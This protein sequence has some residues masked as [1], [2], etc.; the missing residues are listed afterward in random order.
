MSKDLMKMLALKQDQN[1]R[2]Q[3]NQFSQSQR[4][5]FCPRLEARSQAFSPK[6]P[7]QHQLP[8]LGKLKILKMHK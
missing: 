2:Y 4:A 3:D 8:Q 6:N 5:K 1:L 7:R